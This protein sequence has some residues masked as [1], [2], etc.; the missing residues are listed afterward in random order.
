MG[1]GEWGNV[2]ARDAEREGQRQRRLA[3][4]HLTEEAFARTTHRG[5]QKGVRRRRAKGKEQKGCKVDNG[6]GEEEK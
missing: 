6:T 5:E 3:K 2:E 4:Q 1:T